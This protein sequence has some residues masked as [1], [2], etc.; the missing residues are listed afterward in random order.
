MNQR[1]GTSELYVDRQAAIDVIRGAL[2][3]L[4]ESQVP[5][6]ERNPF[7]GYK[8]DETFAQA[9]SLVANADDQT[10]RDAVEVLTNQTLGGIE[11]AENLGRGHPYK[12]AQLWNILL[13]EPE[14]ARALISNQIV[15]FHGTRSGALLSTIRSGFVQSAQESVRQGTLVSTGER[16]MAPSDGHDFVFFGDWGAPET[17]ASY[18][19]RSGPRTLEDMRQELYERWDEL[20]NWQGPEWQKPIKDRM[21]QSLDAEIEFIEQHPSSIEAQLMLANIPI[22]LGL[23]NDGYTVYNSPH[24]VLPDND[25]KQNAIIEYPYPISDIV[26]EFAVERRV[27]LRRF[28]ILATPKEH[29]NWLRFIVTMTNANN[30]QIIPDDLIRSR[31]WEMP[32]P[33]FI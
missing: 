17:I 26:G 20:D 1:F 33:Q 24:D 13:R 14:T 9:E 5:F 6:F 29:V 18:S 31:V 3:P 2:Y 12:L 23:S 7:A 16:I 10:V 11:L 15:G 30:I 21:A 32:Q 25:S 8:R 28:P 27:D 19:A 22:S 4:D